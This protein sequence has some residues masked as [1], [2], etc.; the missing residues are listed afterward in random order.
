MALNK[1]LE[2]LNISSSR[3]FDTIKRNYAIHVQDIKPQMFGGIA[4][5]VDQNHV[6]IQTK[7]R[8]LSSQKIV[9]TRVLSDGF[10]H[11]LSTSISIP[12]TV[13]EDLRIKLDSEEQRIIFVVYSTTKFFKASLEDTKKNSSRLNSFVI[14][15][16]IKGLP[17]K[18]L[19]NPI[20]ISFKT[21]AP[22]D[23]GTTLCSYWDF[24]TNDWT[25]EGCTFEGVIP[26]DKILCKC[27][28]LT[29]F[30]MLMVS[31]CRENMQYFY[32]LIKRYMHSSIFIIFKM[33][34]EFNNFC[35][36]V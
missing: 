18:N 34:K 28:H 24:I 15:G 10:P 22:G 1:F 6:G 2:K 20:K 25:Q 17:V 21:I 26:D 23:T 3:K 29:N 16:S 7:S 5:G 32:S 27:N 33:I 11:N 14:A 30:A 31:S 8:K 13:F 12:P 19:T 35:L 36:L 9:V 4:F